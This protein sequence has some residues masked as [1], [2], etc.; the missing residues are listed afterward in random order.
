[1]RTSFAY[2]STR[3]VWTGFVNR[4]KT[5]GAAGRGLFVARFSNRSDVGP[6]LPAALSPLESQVDQAQASRYK[7]PNIEKSMPNGP[8][9]SVSAGIVFRI[10]KSSK[11]FA[12]QVIKP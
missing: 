5:A 8:R 12:G 4:K 6:V 9:D 2:A 11:G 10:A 7:P 1:M 3:R